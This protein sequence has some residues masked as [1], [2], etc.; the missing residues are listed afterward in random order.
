MSLGNAAET[1][2]LL[3]IGDGLVTQI[4]ALI[5]STAAGMLVTRSGVQGAADEA[6]LGQL[7]NYPVALT[8]ATGLLLT[9]AVLPGIPALPFLILAGV[10]GGIAFA[11]NKRRQEEE[12]EEARVEEENNPRRRW[13]SLSAQRCKSITFAWSSD[14]ACYLSSTIPANAGSQSRS[15]RFAANW[16]ARWAS[17][18]RLY[19]FKIT[20]NYRRTITSCESRK[21]KLATGNF[22]P[23]CFS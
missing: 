16:R 20:F 9:I 2:T 10:T 7:T 3:T 11:L 17:S 8:L 21:S 19:G 14:T 1:Y 12:D 23:I 6:V 22:V 13:K 18:C 4:P 15:R 5:V